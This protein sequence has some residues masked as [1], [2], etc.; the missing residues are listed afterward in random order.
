MT[1][2]GLS[3]YELDLIR[4]VLARFPH[5]TRAVVFGS[6]ANGTF[7]ENSDIDI[8]VDGNVSPLEAESLRGDL[9]ELAIANR[10]DVVAIRHITNDALREHIER[11]GVVLY[12]DAACAPATELQ[13][14]R[15][16]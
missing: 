14:L 13:P 15:Y 10:F 6:R 3:A 12:T 11:V 5:V 7:R 4:S 1:S 16:L 2:L 9:E 8:A